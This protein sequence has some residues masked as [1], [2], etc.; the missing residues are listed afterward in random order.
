MTT[1]PSFEAEAA[2]EASVLQERSR[3]LM[4]FDTRDTGHHIEYIRHVVR[5]AS[6]RSLGTE[7]VGVVPARVVDAVRAEADDGV[8]LV[9]I[10]EESIRTAHE[11]PTPWHRSFAEWRLA[12]RHARRFNV[13]HCVLM[14]LNWFQVALALPSTYRIPFTLSG[15]YFFPFVRLRPLQESGTQ[16]LLQLARVARKW[17]VMGIMMRNPAIES[18]YVLNDAWAATQLND[19]TDTWKR[20]F[21]PLPDPVLPP[22][23]I[24][25]GSFRDAYDL[26]AQRTFFLFAGTVSRR[27][28]VFEALDAAERLETDAQARSALVLAGRLVDDVADAV[29]RRINRLRNTTPMKVCADFRFLPEDELHRAFAGCDA[30]L[31]PYQRVEGSSGLL[32]H[33]AQAQRPVIG[34]NHGLIGELIDRYELGRT[35]DA[36]RPDQIAQAMRAVVDGT[37]AVG[38]QAETYVRER[39][40][41]RF[42]AQLLDHS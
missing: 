42:A 13:D 29:C 38:T 1:R 8:R 11:A 37:V 10:D 39:T 28:G 5:Y 41:E 23:N 18:V 26:D 40:P 27:K 16:A 4:V 33:A 20:R 24:E 30:I 34:P 36:S 21:C 32:G 22:R 7:L 6:R 9:A 2:S 12:E 15:I 19:L 14:D 17:L 31:A 25:G 3:R 35:V